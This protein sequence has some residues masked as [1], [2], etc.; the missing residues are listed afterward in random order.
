[1]LN[2]RSVCLSCCLVIFLG[3]TP[4]AF[5][6]AKMADIQQALDSLNQQLQSQSLSP[7][8]KAAITEQIEFAQQ[9]LAEQKDYDAQ[10]IQYQQQVKQAGTKLAELAAQTEALKARSVEIDKSLSTDA[11]SNSLL[12]LQSEQSGVQ[13]SL[14][15][16]L[17]Q[18]THLNT[19]HADI[20]Q[21]LND[22]RA[23]TDATNQAL[24]HQV[25]A[26]SDLNQTSTR[27]AL[28]AKLLSQ[29]ANIKLLEGEISTVPARQS[30]VEG[31]IAL[32]SAQLASYQ[33][34]IDLI[35]AALAKSQSG[36]AIQMLE[37]A[38]QAGAQFGELALFS[39][40]TKENL[41]LAKQFHQ[42]AI[43]EPELANNIGRLSQ[44]RSSVQQSAQTVER[45]LATGHITDEL[46]VLLR[47]LRVG[48]PEERHLASRLKDIDEASVQYQ[49]NLI[50]W[51][52][53]LRTINTNDYLASVAAGAN[54]Q[55]E[56]GQP[57]AAQQRQLKALVDQQSRLLNRLTDAGNAMIDKL[58]DE[59]SLISEVNTKTVELKTLLDRRLVWLPS[60]SRLS[61]NYLHNLGVSI[62]WYANATAWGKL[63]ETLRQGIVRA[64]VFA[65][66]MLLVFLGCCW[67][68]RPLKASLKRIKTRIGKV[69]SD[70]YWATPLALLE[71][72]ILA[73]PLPVLIG[74]L[75]LLLLM[76]AD[77][78]TFSTSIALA[79][80]ALCSL[81]LTLLFFRSLCRENGIFSA[82]FGWSNIARKQLGHLLTF[83][84]WYQGIATF[85]FTSAMA[86]DVV[87][88]R[89][90]I[91]ILAFMVMSV[92]LAGF[93]F[94]FFRP[95]T[96]IAATISHEASTALLPKVALVIMVTAPL[97]AGA[98]PLFGFFDTAVQLQTKLFQS[99]VIL[100]LVAVGYGILLRMFD[101]AFRRYQLRKVI[102]VRQEKAQ[103]KQIV[104]ADR[105]EGAPLPKAE[106]LPDKNEVSRKMA[107]AGRWSAG[108]LVLVCLWFIW[109]PLLPALGV[110]NEIVL[111]QK[112]GTVDGIEVT[113]PVT[114]LNILF[115]L[116]LFII[117]FIAAKNSKGLLE[118]SYFEKVSMD[119][120]ARYA[121]VTIVGY[122]IAGSTLVFGLSQL[123]IDWSKLQWIV[124][125]L[126]VGLGFGLQ[127]IVANFVSGLIILFERPIRVGDTVTIGSLSGT[128]SNIKIRAT[129]I[130]DFDNR[131]VLLP[132]KSVI[133][134]NVINWTLGNAI[135]RVVINIGVA[136]GSDIRKVRDLLLSVLEGHPDVLKLPAPSVFFTNHGESSLDFELRVFVETPSK[137]LPVTHDINTLINEALTREGYEIPFPQRDVHII[138]ADSQ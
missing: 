24:N 46:A 20:S 64:P 27:L 1:M 67:S 40:I 5:S 10:L 38:E 79:L 88:L 18:Q 107:K 100:I 73:L 137:R 11:L 62:G 21:E 136:Y 94:A 17:N 14:D 44:Q 96:G 34:K 63:A 52:E 118:L 89:Y 124:A 130:T 85:V 39:D 58:A 13:S 53:K 26:E 65:L 3:L 71:T 84:V 120:G 127:E 102:A 90:G 77:N 19:R 28:Q 36:M 37:E 125:A 51:Q 50:L 135:T 86:S 104:G 70:T 48:L 112:H 123:G 108:T 22:I 103:L 78:E 54:E 33:K 134:E 43:D 119:P 132:N 74:S 61:D 42:I 138:S 109:L 15:A 49:L 35:Q 117:G 66:G 30:L 82:H 83:F 98:L 91:A 68:R 12:L 56:T 95:K 2:L 115:S 72:L 122:V 110:V 105:G 114:L 101:V 60:Y 47:R 133:T 55:G 9:S 121:A 99:G 29:Q 23:Q 25:T 92:G 93:S 129:T 31:Q 116:A 87:E 128:V 41:T 6:Q 97:L 59:K 7:E 81:S 32:A 45:V 57:T 80:V 76:G 106:S 131:E 126:G 113:D 75:A 4:R 16:L 111:W 69:N 8:A